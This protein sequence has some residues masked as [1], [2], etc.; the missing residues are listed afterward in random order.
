MNINLPNSSTSTSQQRSNALRTAYVLL[1]AA[2]MNE[3]IAL[4]QA[5]QSGHWQAW[6][7][8]GMVL[9]FLAGI[10]TSIVLIRRG[11]VE[12]GVNLLLAGFLV[13]L[14]VRNSMTTGMGTLLGLIGFTLTTAVAFITM[15]PNKAI[16]WAM[17]GL[18][19]GVF[20]ILFD[21]YVP[22]YR[23]AAPAALRNSLPIVAVVASLVVIIVGVRYFRQ[24]NLQ[25]R[26]TGL[27]MLLVLPLLIGATV[28]ISS[29]AGKE[30]ESQVNAHLQETNAA[31]QTNLT[32]WI[33]Q[34]VDTLDLMVRLP[35]INGM[36]PEQQRPVLQAVASTHPYMYLVSTTDLTGMN[37]ARNDEGELTD[38]SD[39]VWYKNALTGAPVTYQSLIGRTSKKPALVVSTPIMD[40]SGKLIGVG[41]FA[42]DLADLSNK[43]RVRSFGRTGTTY[44]VDAN[45]MLLAHPDPA[46]TQDELRDFSEYPPV[47]ALRQGAVGTYI[48]TDEEGVTWRAYVSALNNGWGVIT[49]Q[50]EAEILTP[51]QS[52]QRTTYTLITI[53]TALMLVLMWWVI[54]QMIRPIGL[55]TE[56]ASAIAAGD[57]N[58]E[59][60][61]T[62]Q[63]EI[64]KLA[65][66]FNSMTSQLRNLISSLEQRVAE[67][68]QSLELAAD[69]SRSVSQVRALDVMLKDAA[70]IIRSRFDLYYV[71]V[72]LSNQAQNMLILQS[73]TGLVGAELVGR[74]HQLPLDTGSINGLAATE[75]HSVV[76]AD[77]AASATFRPNPLLPDTRSEMAVPLL[78][79]DK[80]MG[81]LDLQSRQPDALNKGLL[82]A[83]EALA[84]QLAIAIQNAQLLAETEEARVEVEKQA[85]RMVRAGWTDYLD[86]LHK[87]EK[88]GYV[89][90]ENQVKPMDEAQMAESPNPETAL[91]A[92]ITITGES[93]GMLAVETTNRSPKNTELIQIVA[94]QVAQQIESLRL[95]DSAE[96]YRNEVEQ[97]SRRSTVEGWKE[98]VGSKSHGNLS[99]LY[100]LNTVRPE[101]NEQKIK[102]A[103]V[104]LPLKARDETVGKVAVLGIEEPD[105]YSLE[106]ANAV[107]ERLG[108]HI[109][110]LRLFEET[111]RGQIELDKRARQLAAVARIS[112]A[113]S[114][115]L[116]LEKMLHTVVHLTQRQF[117]LYHAHIFLYNEN[118]GGLKVAACGWK[119]GDPHEGTD[120]T[121]VIPINQEKS[122]V[123]TA[124]RERKA[125]IVND[126]SKDPNW[127][128]NPL[129]PETK[130]EM[131]VPLVIG[132]QI[133]G[134]LDVQSEEV[135]IFTEEDANIQSTLAAQVAT[136]LQNARSFAQAQQQAERESMLNAISQKIQSATS[137]EAVLQIAAREL[138]H[139]L[140][141]PLTIAQLGVKDGKK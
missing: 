36:N 71:Q 122:L 121:A 14:L 81:V 108:T 59:A 87:P 130:A 103:T 97:A 119:E 94:R 126:V 8:A 11:N 51:I 86:A 9:L 74:G 128:P 138:G 60:R 53:A 55:L 27:I 23:Q 56:T 15:T 118:T 58:R 47:A 5:I 38:Y 49:Q 6:G 88:T 1:A 98:Y 72:Y 16:R 84:G 41:M 95:L 77:T 26:M 140:G 44:I 3:V 109:E 99:F 33:E 4:R 105:S 46:L 129:L 134:V 45:N 28:I 32:T 19:A 79:G 63:D 7:D 115:E 102:E 82:P 80:I 120:G 111:K 30:I 89:Y 61:V 69:V 78:V 57:L 43:V 54:R 106:L 70:E 96:R 64:G 22:A 2:L 50:S 136:S 17:V 141:A 113:S 100:D 85:G 34:N 107:T 40:D 75:K 132:D 12:R 25:I 135:N 133:L 62:S 76:I 29:Q 65:I 101:L 48:F 92:P 24:L 39:R 139:A 123:A 91:T 110:S 117:G 37:I 20:F 52:F 93:I 31:V 42:A 116:D 67:R 131:A 114:R 124:A 127:L 137:V 13:T 68:T 73:G 10:A 66:T 112:N 125:V 83:F 90:E 18:A 104:T 21:L 35:A